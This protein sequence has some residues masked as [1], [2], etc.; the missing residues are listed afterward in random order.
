MEN[1]S[2][3]RQKTDSICQ[4]DAGD[5]TTPAEEIL[6]ALPQESA[7]YATDGIEDPNSTHETIVDSESEFDAGSESESESDYEED[8]DE[9]D[10][11]EL[12]DGFG[13]DDEED[14]KTRRTRRTRRTRMTRRTRRTRRKR[15]TRMTVNVTAEATTEVRI[16]P[17]KRYNTSHQKWGPRWKNEGLMEFLLALYSRM[18]EGIRVRVSGDGRKCYS[19][20]MSPCR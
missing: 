17:R 20:S 8:D 9:E 5:A 10:N 3:K 2:P 14:E 1:P 4:S 15:T 6:S 19:T 16:L 12:D 13:D 7:D 11:E 18:L